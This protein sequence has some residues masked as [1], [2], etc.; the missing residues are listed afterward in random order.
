MSLFLVTN[1][2]YRLRDR[3]TNSVLSAMN[4]IFLRQRTRLEQLTRWL[5]PPLKSM[6]RRCHLLLLIPIV[7]SLLHL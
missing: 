2:R 4:S 1:I 7:L 6:F 3:D 5:C